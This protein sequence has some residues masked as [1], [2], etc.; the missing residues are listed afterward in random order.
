M[1]AG[2][3]VSTS[4]DRGTYVQPG[5]T[6]TITV[7]KGREQV[8]IPSVSVGMTYED[9]YKR[10][11]CSRPSYHKKIHRYIHYFHRNSHYSTSRG[12]ET[13]PGSSEYP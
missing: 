12:T 7:S 8:T 2:L 1:R 10:Q 13:A 6:V 9:V 5:S 4:P 3:V 11:D